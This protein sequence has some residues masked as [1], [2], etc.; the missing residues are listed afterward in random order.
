MGGAAMVRPAARSAVVA[1]GVLM[2]VD[3]FRT[4]L[5]IGHYEF[6]ITVVTHGEPDVWVAALAYA[7]FDRV[8]DEFGRALGLPVAATSVATFLW[9]LALLATV[10][11]VVVW[12]RRAR[13]MRHPDRVTLGWLGAAVLLKALSAIYDTVAAPPSPVVGGVLATRPVAYPLWIVSTVVLVVA[14]VRVVRAIRSADPDP[15]VTG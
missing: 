7:L 8:V 6:R 3:V 14:A 5:A 15:A 1:L 9:V 2:V 13:L 12:L 10:V 11:T 4:C